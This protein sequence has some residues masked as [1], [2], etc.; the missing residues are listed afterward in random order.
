MPLTCHHSPAGLRSRRKNPI[1]DF[2]LWFVPRLPSTGLHIGKCLTC[3]TAVKRLFSGPRGAHGFGAGAGAP[4]R[5]P[6]QAQETNDHSK[7]GR[8]RGAPGAPGRT[9]HAEPWPT[10][11]KAPPRSG[12]QRKCSP[13]GGARP[14]T[15]GRRVPGR[16]RGEWARGGASALPGAGRGGPGRGVR[17]VQGPGTPSLL[18]RRPLRA[19][20]AFS[21][22]PAGPG[23]DPSGIRRHG[24]A[25]GEA[26][27]RRGVGAGAGRRRVGKR[28]SERGWEGSRRGGGGPPGEFR[29]AE[30]CGRVC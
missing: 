26:A 3:S 20:A 1:R 18:L 4:E 8:K 30:V 6:A 22:R 27:S 21:E 12:C 25:R 7:S 14:R 15:S 13:R 16:G 9:R 5:G 23:L 10:A 28:G 2:S 24:P 29:R 17:A 19:P 11:R